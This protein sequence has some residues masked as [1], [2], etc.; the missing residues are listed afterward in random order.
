MK[1]FLLIFAIITIYVGFCSAVMA[2]PTLPETGSSQTETPSYYAVTKD[3]DS[4]FFL[5]EWLY[6][7]LDDVLGLRDRDKD[8]RYYPVESGSDY[9]SGS[10]SSGYDGDSGWVIDPDEI[11]WDY[12]PTDGGSGDGGTDSGSGDNGSGTD[13][14]NSGWGDGS[15]G[16]GWDPGSGGGTNPVQTIPAPGALIL[17]CLGAG[18]ISWLRRRRTL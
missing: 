18:I 2:S 16:N 15:G 13:S 14:G 9:D 11:D 10:G 12:D 6:W 7:F 17:G 4:E 1:K 3:S 8:T 5:L